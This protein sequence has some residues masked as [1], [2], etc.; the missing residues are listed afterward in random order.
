MRA[1]PHLRM[2]QNT[3]EL[4]RHGRLQF[5]DGQNGTGLC[6]RLTIAAQLYLVSNYTFNS[7]PILSSM[8]STF[9]KPNDD[10]TFQRINNR[11]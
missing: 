8:D 6:S 1:I 7:L 3:F 2:Q 10:N 4:A 9:T 5:L 11:A